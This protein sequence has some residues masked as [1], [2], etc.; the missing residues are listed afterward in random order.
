[1]LTVEYYDDWAMTI[2]YLDIFFD[3]RKGTCNW[4]KMKELADDIITFSQTSPGF[5]VSVIQDF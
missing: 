1:M 3:D 5:Y 4:S 2:I